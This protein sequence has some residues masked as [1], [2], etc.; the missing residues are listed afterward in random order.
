MQELEELDNLEE[1]NEME[2]QLEHEELDEFV[3][4]E[5]LNV[6]D[7]TV[8]KIIGEQIITA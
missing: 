3:K 6:Q 8:F 2:E 4:Q 5:L 7:I 1:L